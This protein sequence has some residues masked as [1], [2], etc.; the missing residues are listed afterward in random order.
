MKPNKISSIKIHW[1]ILLLFT[2]C[3][4]AHRDFDVHA[5]KEV[6]AGIDAEKEEAVGIDD[7]EASLQAE[8]VPHCSLEDN[9]CW[10]NRHSYDFTDSSGNNWI[11]CKPN[12]R[13]SVSVNDM[14]IMYKYSWT[15]DQKDNND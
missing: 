12:E 4:Y 1:V 10:K 9:E 11:S 2:L 15:T 3:G 6:T 5:E 14:C 13:D 7:W 8:R